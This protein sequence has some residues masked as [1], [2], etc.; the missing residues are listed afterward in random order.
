MFSIINVIFL[1]SW[2]THWKNALSSEM[3]SSLEFAYFS[4]CHLLQLSNFE[5]EFHEN[6][7]FIFIVLA[8]H[9]CLKILSLM[10]LF[11]KTETSVFF[12]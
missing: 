9:R 4:K 2:N 1:S 6:Q 5:C 7:I 3:H 10:L 12:F 8:F 11:S